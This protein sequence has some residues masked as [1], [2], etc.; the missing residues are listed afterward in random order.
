[1]EGQ[2]IV[3]EFL[4]D[5]KHVAAGTAFVFVKWHR[6]DPTKRGSTDF[7][8][9]SLVGSPADSCYCFFRRTGDF[10]AGGAA[11]AGQPSILSLLSTSKVSM[12]GSFVKALATP[13]NFSSV[14]G[15]ALPGNTKPSRFKVTSG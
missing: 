5:F 8:Y 14:P 3:G 1:M 11:C 13:S 15:S 2:R 4:D 10:F 6:H 7:N 12:K 9:T